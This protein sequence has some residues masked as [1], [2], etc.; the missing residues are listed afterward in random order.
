ML[1]CCEGA[2]FDGT[3]ALVLLAACGQRS[4]GQRS[5]SAER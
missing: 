1:L 5:S 3:P 4:Y 2:L